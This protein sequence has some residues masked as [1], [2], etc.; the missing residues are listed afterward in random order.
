MIFNDFGKKVE[1]HLLEKV[2]KKLVKD[3]KATIP[4]VGVL[5]TRGADLTN[6]D[7]RAVY[8]MPSEEFLNKLQTAALAEKKKG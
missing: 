3:G 6:Y 8:F 7:S 5:D 4:G 2:V 1:A